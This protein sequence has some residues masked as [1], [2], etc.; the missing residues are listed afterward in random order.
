VQ[1]EA[2]FEGS[3]EEVPLARSSGLALVEPL[4]P[5][6]GSPLSGRPAAPSKR[7]G[8]GP[9]ISRGY[10]EAPAG[11]VVVAGNPLGGSSVL[12]LRVKDGQQVKRD[13]IL[14]VL[15]TIQ[16][17]D[18]RAHRRDCLAKLKR[19]HDECWWAPASPDRPAG[20][21]PEVFDREQQARVHPTPAVGTPNDQKE[22]EAALQVQSIE[23]RRSGW[24]LPSR[25]E[26]RSGAIEI[27]LANSEA[28]LENARRTPRRPGPLAARRCRVEIFSRQGERISHLGIAKVVD[29]SQLRV[30]ASVDELH[31]ARMRPAP[32]RNHL[33]ERSGRYGGKMCACPSR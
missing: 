5:L 26:E 30:R 11:T 12:E 1:D 21:H 23:R 19:T 31:L 17:R 32:G 15:S 16:R 14:A 18:C 27:D 3:G 8:D 13:E 20:S 22:M 29:M 4:P 10:T 24:S 9:L 28:S 6:C 2:G 7:S 33:Q 25:R